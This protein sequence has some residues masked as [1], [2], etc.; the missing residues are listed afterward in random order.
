MCCLKKK[1]PKWQENTRDGNFIG[2]YLGIFGDLCCSQSSWT[3]EISKSS[4]TG[5]IQS[6]T[7]QSKAE[8]SEL[9][10]GGDAKRS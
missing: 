9:I 8:K 2:I 6:E 4:Q 3:K 1:Q 7:S 5:L 10:K